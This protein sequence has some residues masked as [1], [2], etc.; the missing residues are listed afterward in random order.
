MNSFIVSAVIVV[1]LALVSYSTAVISEQRASRLSKKIL[2]F[3]TC[4]VLLDVAS[5]ALMI[6]GSTNSPF[7]VH[8]VIGYSALLLMV[9]DAFLIWRHWFANGDAIVSRGINL[10]TRIA[11]S[12]WIVAYIVGA[13][14]S[15]RG[16]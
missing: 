14:M 6:T 15:M 16:S 11:F 12:W 3:L 5:T 1:T 13:V 9:I 2:V 8:G 7:T 10:Y 4:G